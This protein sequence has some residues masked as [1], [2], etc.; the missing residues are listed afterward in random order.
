MQS[1]REKQH[2]R[3]GVRF[4]LFAK[5]IVSK[6]L[7]TR[8]NLCKLDLMKIN[9]RNTGAIPRMTIFS[10]V[11]VAQWQQ[12]QFCL[13]SRVRVQTPYSAW[14]SLQLS[15]HYSSEILYSAYVGSDHC[16]RSPSAFSTT[17]FTSSFVY[18]VYISGWLSDDCVVLQTNRS[19]E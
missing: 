16:T 6:E 1:H 19:P 2:S 14:V 15:T 5:R 12:Q 17:A 9:V 13:C 8:N 11:T 4:V 10:T 3:F 18:L 7:R